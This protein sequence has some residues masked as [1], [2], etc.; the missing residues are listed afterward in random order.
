MR[1]DFSWAHTGPMNGK[2][3]AKRATGSFLSEFLCGAGGGGSVVRI[4]GWGIKIDN[5]NANVA[6]A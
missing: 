6:I 5:A 2:H 4:W 1:Q 3:V